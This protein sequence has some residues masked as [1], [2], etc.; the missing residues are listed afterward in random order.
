MPRKV[1]RFSI[2]SELGRGGFGIVFL[3]DDPMLGPRVAL[4]V[5]RVEI[6]SESQGWRRFLREARTASRLDHPNLVPMLEAGAIGPVGYIASAFVEGPTLDQ[7]LRRTRGAHRPVQPRLIATLAGAL[8]HMHARGILHR[9]LKPANILMQAPER[10][11]GPRALAA[12]G[13]AD[14]RDLGATDLRLRAGQA[15]RG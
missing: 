9:D 3:A 4:K 7:C 6:L 10:H 5:P 14:A 15:A 12:M 2:V 13:C 11:G 8:E 1:G